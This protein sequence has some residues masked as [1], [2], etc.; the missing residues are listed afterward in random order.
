MKLSQ[1]T[2]K[3]QEVLPILYS[4]AFDNLIDG[5]ADCFQ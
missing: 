5:T 4:E 3:H 2:A 1:I